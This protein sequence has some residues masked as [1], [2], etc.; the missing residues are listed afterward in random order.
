MYMAMW[1]LWHGCRKVSPGCLNCYVY[2]GDEKYGRDSSVIRKTQNFK[3]PLM[4]TRAGDYKIRPG[5]TLFTC[6]TSDFFLDEA[7]DWRVEAWE[8]IRTRSD[9]DFFIITKRIDR[10]SKV[11][12]EDWGNGYPNVTI[13]VT[14]EN[15]EMADFR[16]PILRDAPIRKK[17]IICE[18]LLGKIDLSPYLGP[19]IKSVGVGGESG[20][21][22]RVCDYN[23]VLDIQHQCME[24]K[25]PFH[26]KQ[27]GARLLK[28]GKLYCIK[29]RDQHWQAKK[30][31]IDLHY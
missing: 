25:I 15:Q 7:D 16:L 22:A 10:F 6:F 12:P 17:G 14:T 30:A 23:W 13:Y 21:N 9:L 11:I 8:M 4:K 19:W 28:D 26:F 20:I 1:N 18:P 29:R 5:E 24:A 31:D 2:R 27:T 3:L